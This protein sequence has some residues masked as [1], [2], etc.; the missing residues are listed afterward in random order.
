MPDGKL[1]NSCSGTLAG[2]VIIFWLKFRFFEFFVQVIKIF[3][4][5]NTFT[6]V[7]EYQND[8][9]VERPIRLVPFYRNWIGYFS[10]VQGSNGLWMGWNRNL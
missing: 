3:G 6:N 1:E 8:I 5:K 9:I 2:L 10:T 7:P 4:L